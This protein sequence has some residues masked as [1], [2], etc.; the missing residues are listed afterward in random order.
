MVLF[1]EENSCGENS[2][3]T[4]MGSPPNK[5]KEKIVGNL[6]KRKER[7]SR[8]LDLDF[9]DEMEDLGEK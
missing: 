4:L 6:S 1:D 5:G 3:T 8:V 7:I 2:S 9:G